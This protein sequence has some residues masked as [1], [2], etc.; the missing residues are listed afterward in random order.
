MFELLK[1]GVNPEILKNK[2]CCKVLLN[3]NCNVYKS[4]QFWNGNESENLFLISNLTINDD[5][6]F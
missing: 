1:A 2:E 5:F 6:F 4:I 3:Y